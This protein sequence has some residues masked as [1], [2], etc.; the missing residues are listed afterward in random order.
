[1]GSLIF[2]L[3]LVEPC[4]G[5]LSFH[6]FKISYD[7]A[8]NG[9]DNS[10]PPVSMPWKIKRRRDRKRDIV[11]FVLVGLVAIGAWLVVKAMT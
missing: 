10:T 2:N 5:F 7:G 1:M 11:M 9:N 6:N 8:I 4:H 3:P